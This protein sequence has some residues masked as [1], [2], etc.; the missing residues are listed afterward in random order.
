MPAPLTIRPAAET[1]RAA[2]H[3]LLTAQ[4]LEHRL[5]AD[6][7]RVGRGLDRAF[8]LPTAWLWLAER[9]GEAVAVLLANEIASV[10]RGGL[11]LWIEE[12]YVAPDARR[13]GIAR[14]MM[15]RVRD[16]AS[17]RGVH[18]IELEVVPSQAAAFA[19]YRS[20]GFEDVHR[21]RLSLPL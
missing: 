13:G 19:L 14:A 4:L 20:L 5:P 17:R 15:A 6:A 10:E 3:R 12:L 11:A 1:D 18:A 21:Q 7:G 16:E 2:V 8:A 9:S